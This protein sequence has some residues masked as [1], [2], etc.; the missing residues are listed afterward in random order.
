[1]RIELTKQDVESIL[2]KYL[3][4]DAVL[5][6]NNGSAII[7]TTL[8]KIISN[9]NREIIEYMDPDATETNSDNK[10]KELINKVIKK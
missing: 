7:D 2:K 3:N 4:M 8:E 5:L 9:E 10:I 1:M 6:K